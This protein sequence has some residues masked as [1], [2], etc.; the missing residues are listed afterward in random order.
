MKAIKEIP[1]CAAI[2]TLL[3]LTNLSWMFWNLCHQA[4][5]RDAVKQ[6]RFELLHTNGISGIG[7]FETKSDQ[8][9]W[10]RYTEDGKPV[11]ENHFFDGKD[12]F[13]IILST[14]HPPKYNVYF[15][16][17]GKSVTWWMDDAGSGCFTE[18]IYYNTNGDFYKREVWYKEAWH[19]VNRRNERNGILING[20][21]H[22][23]ALDT[24]GL[25]TTDNK[26]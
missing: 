22:Q 5:L 18:R 21:W 24:N 4:A 11:I 20:Q 3:L 6:F 2:L 23:L 19:A 1:V 9:V 14:N 8:P 17:A 26:Q 16:G 15:R 12:V 13:D 25:W 7:L 10:T